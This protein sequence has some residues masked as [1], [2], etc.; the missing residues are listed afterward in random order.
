MSNLVNPCP[1]SSFFATFVVGSWGYFTPP[2]AYLEFYGA[3]SNNIPTAIPMFS[4]S[5]LLMVQLPASHD[6]DIRQKS[7]MAVAKMKRKHF[8]AVWPMKDNY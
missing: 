4:G 2:Q 1:G 5:N 6:V 3:H 7:K 8:T